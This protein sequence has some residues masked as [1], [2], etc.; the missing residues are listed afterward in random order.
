[1][2]EISIIFKS[3]LSHNS[4]RNDSIT[5]FPSPKPT[6][7]RRCNNFHYLQF[8]PRLVQFPAQPASSACWLQFPRYLAWWALCSLSDKCM[9]VYTNVRQ[10]T[11]RKEERNKSLVGRDGVICSSHL[12]DLKKIKFKKG[13]KTGSACLDWGYALI[14]GNL[15]QA[16]NK[17]SIGQLRIKNV[18]FVVLNIYE[19]DFWNS[20]S[21]TDL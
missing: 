3:L 7:I 10:Q 14:L 9:F 6:Y 4:S 20:L 18:S 11:N 5:I 16:N 19:N 17:N 12:L 2:K 15:C 21:D 13:T 8:P 1:M